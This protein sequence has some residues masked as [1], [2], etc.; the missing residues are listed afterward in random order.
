MKVATGALPASASLYRRVLLLE[1][2][3]GVLLTLGSERR[4]GETSEHLE[5]AACG[6][7][8][9]KQGAINEREMLHRICV[10][11]CWGT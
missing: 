5:W 1:C 10:G 3:G 4:R 6:K 8:H 11:R 9:N 7:M 2:A